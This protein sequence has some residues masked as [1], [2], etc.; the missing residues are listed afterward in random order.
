MMVGAPGL[1]AAGSTN[2]HDLP[3]VT[4]SPPPSAEPPRVSGTPFFRTPLRKL[5]ALVVAIAAALGGVVAWQWWQEGPLRDAEAALARSQ[6]PR[7]LALAEYYLDLHPGSERAEAD[8]ARALSELGRADEAIEIYKRIGAAT[9]DELRAWARAHMI[10][11]E[12]SRAAP[13]LEQCLRLRPTDADA[14]Y[15]LTTCR[16]RLGLLTEALESAERFT[17]LPGQGARG[18]I[19]LG[20]IE[21][22]RSHT[23]EAILAYQRAEALA[24][25]G[26]G[27][28]LPPEEFFEQFG[29]LLLNQGRDAEAIPLFER[30]LAA[31]PTPS[32]HHLLGKALARTGD[33]EGARR[34]WNAAI[35]L[36][37]AGVTPREELAN[38]ELVAGDAMAAREWL[39]PLEGLAEQRF[40]SAYLFQRLAALEKDDAAFATRK[41]KADVL[42]D[43]QQLI[44]KLEQM[45]ASSPGSYWA[46]VVRAHKF[47]TLG[48]RPQAADLINGIERTDDE[49]PFVTE[50]RE[51]VLGNGPLPALE[52]VPLKQF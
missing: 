50:L 36:D 45:M 6:A 2:L 22:D 18:N 52:R 7:A 40:E 23:D 43:R 13:L 20:A 5:L 32:S 39:I 9:I 42:R 1:S 3:A 35:E 33:I 46:E 11:N 31:R 29:T 30:S 27:L 41:E 44:A 47:A 8:R 49:D 25:D 51:A 21:A 14:L 28:Q 34:N 38:L 16:T 26:L 48:N 19:L 24:P 37:P 4:H 10:R 15:E 17:A 12:W